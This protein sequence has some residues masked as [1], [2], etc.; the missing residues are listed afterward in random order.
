MYVFYDNEIVTY[1]FVLL[2]LS[3]QTTYNIIDIDTE[4]TFYLQIKL[5]FY[6]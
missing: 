2:T 3:V 6:F 5:A 4:E 1:D